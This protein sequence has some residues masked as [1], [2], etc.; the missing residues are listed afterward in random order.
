MTTPSKKTV[1]SIDMFRVKSYIER[2]LRKKLDKFEGE[3]LT[4]KIVDKMKGECIEVFKD[5]PQRL[6]PRVETKVVQK[7]RKVQV[8]FVMPI[9]IVG[10][11]K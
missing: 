3:E 8:T 5:V 2:E 6:V 11:E 4:K 7:G 1:E 10:K 9:W